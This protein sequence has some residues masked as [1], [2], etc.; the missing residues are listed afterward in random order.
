MIARR[1]LIQA[2]FVIYVL[3][4]VDQGIGSA[5]RRYCCGGGV[6]FPRQARFLQGPR[7]FLRGFPSGAVEGTGCFENPALLNG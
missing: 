1:P 7:L 2:Y 5:S 6:R 3:L 4:T